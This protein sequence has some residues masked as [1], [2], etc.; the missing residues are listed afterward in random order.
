M[1]DWNAIRWTDARQVAELA[2]YGEDALPAS[3]VAVSDHYAKVRESGSPA[4]ALDFIGHALSRLEAVSWAAKIIDEES[5]TRTLAVRDRLAL[6]TVLRW[7]GDPDDANRRAAY[8]AAMKAR[9][10]APERTLG[11]AVFFSGGSISTPDL[12]PV[13]PPS[14][15]ASRCAVTA[16]KQAAYRNETPDAVF[17][18][19]L[20]LAEAIAEQGIKALAPA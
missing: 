1:S 8:D 17:E 2:G 15:S 5:R 14:E 16:I 19:A 7:I 11:M 3:E 6:D 10:Q 12:Q 13:L 20:A 18:R 4:D 9:E